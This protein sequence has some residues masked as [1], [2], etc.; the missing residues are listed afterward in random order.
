YCSDASFYLRYCHGYPVE[1]R[2]M[3]D[4]SGKTLLQILRSTQYLVSYYGGYQDVSKMGEL[5]LALIET[6]AQL[7]AVGSNRS[8]DIKALAATSSWEKQMVI[9]PNHQVD[10]PRH[11]EC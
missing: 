4:Q 3:F 1:V 9:V 7:E 10:T 8:D 2:K 6:I 5:K 11:I